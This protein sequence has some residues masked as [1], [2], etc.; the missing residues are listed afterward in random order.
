MAGHYPK[1]LAPRLHIW[2][3]VSWHWTFIRVAR[4]RGGAEYFSNPDRNQR[5]NGTHLNSRNWQNDERDADALRALTFEVS[6]RQ[7]H[8]TRPALQIMHACT[9][10]RAW[11]QAV[12]SQLDRRVR[13]LPRR[14]SRCLNR[15]G[16]SFYLYHCCVLG[17]RRPQDYPKRGPTPTGGGLNRLT[18]RRSTPARSALDELA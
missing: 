1:A 17:V 11:W 10:A 16:V 13:P 12:G 9:V 3:I 4:S 18:A 2:H 5:R 15:P 7:R 14:A 8:D 6:W